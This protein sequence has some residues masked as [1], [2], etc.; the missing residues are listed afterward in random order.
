MRTRPR[1][2]AAACS[3]VALLVAGFSTEPL[4]AQSE[5]KFAS[6]ERPA[7]LSCDGPISRDV[8]EAALVAAF[9]ARNVVS[10]D[11]Y[12]GE[13]A[14]EPGTAIYPDDEARRIEI[15]WH[16][17]QQRRRPARVILHELSGTRFVLP[18]GEVLLPGASLA[19][20]EAANGRPFELSGFGW[21]Y[22]GA[23]TDWRGGGLGALP[24]GCLLFARF[25]EGPDAEPAALARVAGDIAFSSDDPAMRA[26]RPL[27][28]M[29]SFG[30]AQ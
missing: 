17:P 20:I 23:V 24:G 19:E 29:L 22:G 3:A 13:G 27:L 6:K 18:G 8:D 7:I 28:S 9:G 2:L 14:F 11:I 1:L 26:A 5:E 16:D 21:D 4:R 12:V 25:M 30:W 15:L 10:E